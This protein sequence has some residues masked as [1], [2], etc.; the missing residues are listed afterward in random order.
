[1]T[2][3]FTKIIMTSTQ[4][5]VITANVATINTTSVKSIPPPSSMVHGKKPKKPNVLNFK[6]WKHKILFYLIIL[7][8]TK[9]LSKE[10]PEISDNKFNPF[11]VAIV[12]ALNHWDFVC[13]NY[14]LS[15]LD[16]TL[17]DVYS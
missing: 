11:I 13:K 2:I 16:N 5:L 6:R 9:L 7:N 10:A 14:I 1:M 12:D 17:Y 4:E 3:V 8:L 15:E